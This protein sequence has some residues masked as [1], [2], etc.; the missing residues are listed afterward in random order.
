MKQTNNK[1]REERLQVVNYIRQ[2]LIGPIDGPEEEVIGSP[3]DRYLL[4]ILY[5]QVQI[6]DETQREE[7]DLLS[8][9]ENNILDL[10]LENPVNLAYER[11]PSSLGISFYL[12]GSDTIECSVTAGIYNKTEN[13]NE[14]KSNEW[15]R[16]PLAESNSPKTITITHTKK[17]EIEKKEE[18]FEGRA[19][20]HSVWRPYGLG[21]IVT[22]SLI[23]QIKTQNRNPKPNECIFQSTL[24]CS[25]KK[26]KISDY[27]NLQDYF[28]DHE[29][30][31]LA[32]LYQDKKTYAVGHGCSAA[33]EYKDGRIIVKS[34]TMPFHETS[35][36]IKEFSEELIK[37]H[38]FDSQILSL[39]Y[40]ADEKIKTTTLCKRLLSFVESYERWIVELS[41][42]SKSVQKPLHEAAS[43]I[44]KNL[45]TASNRMKRAIVCI[46]KDAMVAKCFRLATKAMLMQM[47]HSSQN[48]G[49]G[50]RDRNEINFTTPPYIGNTVEKLRWF[51]FQLAFQLL[52]LE[53]IDQ[54]NVPERELVDLIWFPTGGGKT[55]AYLWVA[56]F[57][58]FLRRLRN[59]DRGSGTAVIIR[60]TLSLLTVQQFQR[61]G[62]LI[63][64]CEQLRLINKDLGTE[65]FTLGL[66]VGGSSSP[67]TFTEA[68]KEYL[69][70]L[71]SIQPENPF[72]LQKCPWCGTRIIPYK[73]EKDKTCYGVQAEANKFNFF[74]PTDSCAF[75]KK[76]PVGVIDDELFQN[77]PTILIGTIDK[78]ARLAWDYR[79]HVFFGNDFRM[80][81]GLIIQDELHLISGPLGTIAGI[82]EAAIDCLLSHR[83][84]KP[85]IIAATAT[86]RRAKDQARKLYAKDV[87]LFPPSGISADDSYFA[88]TDKNSIGRL[89]IGIMGQGNTPVTSMV[90][91]AAAA[92]QAPQEL[93]A[94]SEEI[95]NTYW[96]LLIYHNSKR[97]LGKTMNLAN[98]D[99]PARIKV[100]AKDESNMRKPKNVLE[101]SSNI[102]GKR[103]NE[104][105][106]LMEKNKESGA[107]DIIPCTNMF[108]VGVDV[109]RLGIMMV[110]GQP[111]TTAE[112]IQA[113][114]RVGRD[115]VPGLVVT[116]YSSAKPRD[117]SHYEQFTAYHNALYRWV[118]PTSVTPFAQPAR[119]RALHAALVIVA[120][121]AGGIPY[122]EDAMK[123]SPDA[124]SIKTLI[125]ML[126]KRTS[127]AEPMESENTKKHIQN[128]VEEWAKKARVKNK[129]LAYD[130]S[131]G[132]QVEPLLC[133]FENP[134]KMAWKTLNSMRQVD[135]ESNILVN[136]ETD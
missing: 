4:G 103:K 61:A 63:C 27:P 109:K 30:E 34:T 111:K 68:K 123:F 19:V 66:W 121:H 41:E 126:I 60:Y 135:G 28:S 88:Q 75:H 53:S 5:P 116:M 132:A 97:E 45:F 42:K 74:C 112:Y 39:Q 122:N 84:I 14:D 120:R 93:K 119:E 3:L 100:I 108:S 21:H 79:S 56:A 110:N 22:V 36:V 44:V 38:G 8:E 11:K 49:G 59:G 62:T 24:T 70:L 7:Y 81:P 114:S 90:R 134:V 133:T 124:K 65:P 77:P 107:I 50:I 128:L 91:A 26:G 125:N 1:F 101:L 47:V 46:E 43:R 10:E 35:P 86:I 67:N 23:N 127:E 2:Q 87:F 118:E 96:T 80:A 57:E 32:L 9:A 52:T 102:L 99:I 37:K 131:I 136:G 83:G 76:I 106:Q 89:Y 48:F 69:G 55:E 85:K 40:L 92:L 64:A 95:K 104:V 115:K 33:W 6:A 20:I 12:E 94:L 98:D 78:F 71:E 113:T 13:E 51:P 129:P 54:P 16:Q 58:M 117:R 130:G 82:Y 29:D 18:L 31:E 72:I 105:L 15:I 17:T 73:H 25:S